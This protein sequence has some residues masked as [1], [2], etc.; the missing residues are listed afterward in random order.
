MF[1]NIIK[2]YKKIA[3]F[4]DFFF[5]VCYTVFIKNNLKERIKNMKQF[6]AILLIVVLSLSIVSCGGNN[7]KTTTSS[8]TTSSTTSS[9]TTSSSTPDPGPDDPEPDFEKVNETVYVITDSLN[10]RTSPEFPDDNSN[11][12]TSYDYGDSLLRV[13]YSEAW[14]VLLIDGVEYYASSKYLTTSKIVTEF[15]DCEE[16]VYIVG[17]DSIRIRSKTSLNDEVSTTVDYKSKGDELLRTGVAV[18]ADGEGIIWSRVE[19]LMENEDGEEEVVEGFINSKYLATEPEQP[20]KP[21][22]NVTINPVCDTVII[23]ADSLNLRTY[24][25]YEDGSLSGLSATKDAELLRVGLASEP[26]EDGITWSAVVFEGNI[27]FISSNPDYIKVKENSTPSNKVISLFNNTYSIELPAYFFSVAETETSV[28]IS[29]LTNIISVSYSGD[30]GETTMT[31]SEYAQLLITVLGIEA[32]V[33]E[34]DGLVYFT[35]T[36]EAEG[37]STFAMVAI[38]ASASGNAFYVTTFEGAGDAAEL[39]EAF[40]EYAKGITIV[41]ADTAE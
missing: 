4:V 18:E 16:L 41:T 21:E 20:E 19:F 36:V 9:S 13:G 25:V 37:S 8:S 2:Y 11:I 22:I 23:L 34:E 17:I 30:L 33:V 35:F 3:F 29:S 40:I 7:N 14:S 27:Y 6:I 15:D 10:I 32:T 31:A 38:N 12:H 26:D 5:C 39:E 1:L 24:P 28:M